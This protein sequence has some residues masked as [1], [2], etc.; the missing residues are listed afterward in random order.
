MELSVEK[1]IRT[2]ITPTKEKKLLK[3][4][5]KSSPRHPNILHNHI[6]R[7]ITYEEHDNNIIHEYITHEY[8][9]HEYI[10]HE[11]PDNIVPELSRMLYKCDNILNNIIQNNITTTEPINNPIV[12]EPE[13]D[14]ECPICLCDLERTNI[15]IPRCKHTI[16]IGCYTRNI[17]LNTH[18]GN[19]CSI[20]RECII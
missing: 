19:K 7:N 6:N 12:E 14:H 2:G 5:N 20:C 16:C 3:T 9:T 4:I 1:Y 8:I 13:T 11:A 15:V 17:I 18:T 10:T